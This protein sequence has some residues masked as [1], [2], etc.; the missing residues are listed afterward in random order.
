MVA[1]PTCLPAPPLSPQIVRQGGAAGGGQ[2]IFGDEALGG[3]AGG[4]GPVAALT[5]WGETLGVFFGVERFH[6]AVDPA[7]AE[8]DFDQLLVGDGLF[9]ARFLVDQHPDLAFL[10]AVLG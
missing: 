2:A 6:Q 1:L 4:V 5:A 8:G 7:V 3:G 10:F 9:A